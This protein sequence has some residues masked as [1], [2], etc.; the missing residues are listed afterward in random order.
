[1]VCLLLVVFY[2][3]DKTLQHF[4]GN[5]LKWR[6]M[7]TFIQNNQRQQTDSVTLVT[8]VTTIANISTNILISVFACVKQC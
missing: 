3:L 8:H 2:S 4:M 6:L 5:V 7:G 1:M